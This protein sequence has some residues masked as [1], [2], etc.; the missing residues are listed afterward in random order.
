MSQP[1]ETTP[2]RTA[3]VVAA[4]LLALAAACLREYLVN[5]RP[6]T[7][8]FARQQ[9]LLYYWKAYTLIA[10][11]LGTVFSAVAFA[12][13][14][15]QRTHTRIAGRL[16]KSQMAALLI[17]ISAILCG[18]IFHLSNRQFGAFDEGIIVDTLW[19]Q[20]IGQLAYHDLPTTNPPLFVLP[21]KLA[22]AIFG[23]RW[24]AQS[25]LLCLFSA[26]TFFWTYWLTRRLQISHPLALLLTLSTQI[27]GIVLL[28]FWWFNSITA[29]AAGLFLLSAVL[30]LRRPDDRT[31]QAS[32]AAALALLL[33]AKP[34]TAGLLALPSTLLLLATLQKRLRF[35]ALT[36]AGLLLSLAFLLGNGVHPSELL[37]SYAGVAKS[38]AFVFLALHINPFFTAEAY[39]QL[40][41]LSLP[42][43]VLLPRLLRS[44][45]QR[46]YTDA[47]EA[48]LVLLGGT[49]G[50]FGA[51]SNGDL[52]DT[53]LAPVG[54]AAGLVALPR[55]RRNG[56]LFVFTTALLCALLGTQI[57]KAES[58]F[59]N[60][61]IGFYFNTDGTTV[62][63]HNPFFA[64][65]QTGP[66][67][68]AVLDQIAQ[69]TA[70]N[71]GPI[72]FAPRLEW[73]YAA[74]HLPSPPGLPVFWQ[75]GTSF[76]PADEAR[77]LADWDSRRFTT[78]I[79]ARLEP[80]GRKDWI[81][82]PQSFQNR[83]AEKYDMDDTTY[84]LLIVWHRRPGT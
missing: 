59:R 7:L 84:P 34:N 52:V 61:V 54:L 14:A 28:S 55:P 81:Y 27:S 24:D 39:F 58:R 19:R 30:L 72:F 76:A 1:T 69:A 67:M 73:A 20:S 63:V 56:S 29:V 78:V 75:S 40:A 46:R 13:P 23:V 26:A 44:L 50:I 47:A 16:R 60:R 15:L 83:L 4:F 62:P 11:L 21:L 77:L 6:N 43:L 32:Y 68:N 8:A 80:H 35:L 36:A 74:F 17:A 33:L 53:G 22:A 10:A 9:H 71:P 18:I 48:L 37:A 64:H 5:I 12:L 57:Y 82:Y 3:P 31:A 2:P 70:H 66:M 38:R 45:T 42:L 51:I 41:C 79:Q 25:Y 65:M 49:V